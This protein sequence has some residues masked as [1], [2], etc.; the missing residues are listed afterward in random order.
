MYAKKRLPKGYKK[1]EVVLPPEMGGGAPD[2]EA[3]ASDTDVEDIEAEAAPGPTVFQQK[4][5]AIPVPEEVIVAS[6][7]TE[8][9]EVVSN[10][11]DRTGL[12]RDITAFERLSMGERGG[13]KG[14][15]LFAKH[16]ANIKRGLREF[17]VSDQD[18]E[19]LELRLVRSRQLAF[20]SV[21]L[22]L[23]GLIFTESAIAD[24]LPRSTAELEEL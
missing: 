1:P 3:L 22:G 5:V 8:E 18:A 10:P 12:D 13:E 6:I 20:V 11:G 16:L 2:T 7:P 24:A 9:V 4:T 21:E 17:S 14:V 15:T 23:S 19:A